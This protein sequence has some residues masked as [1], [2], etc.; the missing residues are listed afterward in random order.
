MDKQQQ[1]LNLLGL[2]KRAGKIISGEELVVKAIKN[3]QAKLVFVAS[4]A[5]ANLIKK[6]TDKSSYYEVTLAQ[7]FSEIE[8]SNAIGTHRKVIAIADNGFTKKM[9][10]LMKM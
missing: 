4:D 2:A 7:N 10:S 5:S 1:L 6:I 3:G 9:E 8:L